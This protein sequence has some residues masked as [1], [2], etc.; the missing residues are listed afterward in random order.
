MTGGKTIKCRCITATPTPMQ[1]HTSY[2]SQV[3][4]LPAEASPQQLPGPVN[5]PRKHAPLPEI[6]FSDKRH[7][8]NRATFHRP[9]CL[10]GNWNPCRA[11]SPVDQSR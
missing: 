7:M 4:N 1:P 5:R 6:P 10:A 9:A 8:K 3:H 11:T 2:Q